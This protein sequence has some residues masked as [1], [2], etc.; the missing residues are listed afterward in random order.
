MTRLLF[1]I[2]CLFVTGQLTLA[3]SIEEYTISIQDSV[4]Y[5][6]YQKAKEMLENLDVTDVT[7]GVLYERGFPFVDLKS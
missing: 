2:C 6:Y 3:Q 4:D 5:N 1:W 7:S